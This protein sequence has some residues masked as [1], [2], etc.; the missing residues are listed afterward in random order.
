MAADKNIKITSDQKTRYDNL[1]KKVMDQNTPRFMF[2]DVLMDTYDGINNNCES[3][4]EYKEI[5]I[6][7]EVPIIQEVVKEIIVEKVVYK[8]RIVETEPIIKEVIVEVP[9]EKIVYRDVIKEAKPKMV[10]K[11]I[12]QNIVRKIKSNANWVNEETNFFP[13]SRNFEIKNKMSEIIELADT[14]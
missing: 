5:E 2:F 13:T 12:N 4:T 3:N 6:I 1:M 10:N 11:A 7:K 14:L 9:V 8:D